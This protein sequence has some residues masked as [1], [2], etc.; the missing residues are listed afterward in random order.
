MKYVALVVIAFAA[1]VVFDNLKS[2]PVPPCSSVCGISMETHR[3]TVPQ[4]ATP[5]VPHPAYIRE[6]Q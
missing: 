3:G 4:E 1:L 2:E 5:M 6:D